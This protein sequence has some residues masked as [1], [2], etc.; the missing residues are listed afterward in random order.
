MVFYTLG[1]HDIWQ[2]FVEGMKETTWL[3]YIVGVWFSQKENILV[4]PTGLLNTT[5][6]W[7]PVE[8]PGCKSSFLLRLY[9][10][11]TELAVWLF[12]FTRIFKKRK[13]QKI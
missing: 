11:F 7:W 9:S 5:C 2:Q 3:E 13:S 4:Y 8:Q 10:M 6:Y 1:L 12:Y